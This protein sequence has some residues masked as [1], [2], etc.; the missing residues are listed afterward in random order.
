MPRQKLCQHPTRH[1]DSS[2]KA[3]GSRRISCR[4]LN[5]LR[6]HYDFEELN[7]RWLCPKC[8]RVETAMMNKEYEMNE[9]DNMDTSNEES[10]DDKSSHDEGENDNESDQQD[11]DEEQS[12]NDMLLELSYREEQAIGQLSRTRPIRSQI[13]QVYK[14][15]HS[16]CDVLEGKS[17]QENDPDP[18]GLLV[19]ESNDLLTGLKSL[20]ND[21]DCSEQVR[22][23]TIAPEAWGREKLR[24][25]FESTEHQARQS[26]ILRQN[27]GVLAVPQYFSG[28]PSISNDTITT[29]IDF[30]R[31]EGVSR[32]SPNSKDT[33][34]INRNTVPL[35]FMEM[36]VLDAFRLFD[37]RFPNMAARTTFYSLRPRDV[38]ILSPHDTCICII[39]ENMNLLIKVRIYFYLQHAWNN[40][41]QNIQNKSSSM[42][43]NTFDLKDLTSQMVCQDDMEDCFIG[44]CQQCST[45]SIIDILTENM[46]VD[47]DENYSWTL[48]KKLNSKFDLQRMTGSIEALL[49]EIEEQW[50][51]FMLHTFCNRKQRDYISDLRAQSTKTTFVVAQIDFSMNYTLI[52][53]REVQQGFFSQSQVSLFTVHL[54]V[55]KEHFDMAIISNSMEH[56][57]A[58]VYCAQQIIVDYVKKNIP[59]AKKIIYVSDG[60]SSHFK[61]NA[62]MLNLAYHKDDFNMDADWVFTATGHGKGPGDGI[63]AVLKSTARRI[64]L[65]KNILLSNPYDFFQFSKK[66]QLETATAAGR[67]KPAIDLFFLEEVEIHRNKALGHQ[68]QYESDPLFTHNIHKIAALAFLKLTNVING[69][70]HLS[71]D[72]GDDNETILDYFEET[73]IGERVIVKSSRRHAFEANSGTGKDDRTALICVSA[74]GFVLSPLFL[75]SGKHLMDS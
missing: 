65:S 18:H 63:G 48:W 5:F 74:G 12:D 36:S 2:S 59:L 38:K 62:N 43:S 60:A 69:F 72:L 4:L 71:I 23:L 40:Y 6:D 30:Y 26:L 13:D 14:Y 11:S 45:K 73:Y 33:I 68:N 3:T 27:E 35:R 70:E 32:T 21:S 64:T 53:Q 25:W 1:T 61:N 24:K 17:V 19:Q 41:R 46:N 10:N 42:R 39:H 67:R 44:E 56:N 75:Y 50:P 7:I 58:F 47:L 29:I 20:F 51:L 28:N 22:L 52:R 55:G 57:V 66:H 49:A 31:E 15:L 34:Q 8:Q 37:E 16:L 54:T 9:E